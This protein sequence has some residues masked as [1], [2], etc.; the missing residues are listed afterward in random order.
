MIET[1]TEQVQRAVDGAGDD[2]AVKAAVGAAAASAAM[3]LPSLPGDVGF[4]WKAFVLG[5]LGILFVA[6][7]GI[8]YGMTIGKPTDVFVTVF[9]SVFAGLVGLFVKSPVQK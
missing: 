7:G 6:L 9:S 2:P 8:I 4:I 1:I 3:P 5:L